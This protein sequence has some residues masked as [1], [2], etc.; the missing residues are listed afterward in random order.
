MPKSDVEYEEMLALIEK[1]QA[2]LEYSARQLIE[3]NKKLG[4]KMIVSENGVIR[5]IEPEDL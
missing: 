2:A 4:R 1:I 3:K 5:T